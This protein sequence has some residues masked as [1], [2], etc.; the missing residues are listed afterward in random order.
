MK[1]SDPISDRE[2]RALWNLLWSSCVVWRSE[3][4]NICCVFML[5]AQPAC[6]FKGPSCWCL[7]HCGSVGRGAD[8]KLRGQQLCPPREQRTLAGPRRGPGSMKLIMWNKATDL[9][10]Y[11]SAP[12]W[13]QTLKDIVP[14]QSVNPWTGLLV[15]IRMRQ[16]GIIWIEFVNQQLLL[17]E[18]DARKQKLKQSFF[19]LI[20]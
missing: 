19:T 12:F 9:W 17:T 3:W 15:G 1:C 14:S 2:Q 18:Q 16:I 6:F 5:T 7:Q 20:S 10:L 8:Q 11:P 13:S 4:G